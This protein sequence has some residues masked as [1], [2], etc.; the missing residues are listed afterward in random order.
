LPGFGVQR[1]KSELSQKLR[2][3]KW[4][5]S[6]SIFR[7]FIHWPENFMCFIS[8]QA[9]VYLEGAGMWAARSFLEL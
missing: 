8:R 4:I 3:E 1:G 9:K 7:E 2:E 6:F 5:F